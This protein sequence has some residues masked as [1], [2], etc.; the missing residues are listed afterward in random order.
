MV[1]VYPYAEFDA[2]FPDD[3]VDEGGHVKF[4]PGRNVAEAIAEILRRTG[5]NPAE[6]EHLDVHGWG[7]HTKFKKHSM[8]I[9]LSTSEDAH[10][11]M[12][13]WNSSSFIDRLTKAAKMIHP[14]FLIVLSRELNADPRFHGITWFS[15]DDRNR[16]AGSAKPVDGA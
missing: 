15:R 3:Q 4:F 5:L 2:D 8:W 12:Y 16:E 9:Q 14:E 1:K 13:T 6:P 7:F 11:Y 10:F